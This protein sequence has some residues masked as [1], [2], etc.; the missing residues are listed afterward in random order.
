[1]AKKA[2]DFAFSGKDKFTIKQVDEQAK[3]G[4]VAG[5]GPDGSGLGSQKSGGIPA[6][7]LTAGNSAVGAMIAG[8]KTK[9]TATDEPVF[10]DIGSST[11]KLKVVKKKTYSKLTGNYFID[12]FNRLNDYLIDHSKIK[13]RD[14]ATFFRLLAIMLNSGVPLIKSLDTL[15]IQSEKSPKLKN[16]IFDLARS[17]EKGKSLSQA[18]TPYPEVFTE[19]QIGM[20]RSGEVTGQLNIILSDLAKDAESSAQIQNKVK[21]AMTYPVVILVIMTIV[22]VIMMVMVLPQMA[23]LFTQSGQELPLITRTLIAISDFMVANGWVILAGIGG[24]VAVIAVILK[25]PRGHYIWDKLKLSLPVFGPIFKKSAL[26]RFASSLGNL[27]ASGI[28]IVQSLQIVSKA[29]GNDVYKRLL[30][31]AA[32]DLKKGIPLAENLRESKYFPK[33]LVNM[34]EVGEQTA[35]LEEVTRKISDFYTDEVN[36]TVASLSK[37]MEPLLI[38]IIGVLVGGLVAAI[39]L[40]IMQ[41]TEVAGSI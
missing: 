17:V 10:F 8:D 31:F 33:M 15:A 11:S 38:A 28:S 9:V 35:Q 29:I 34:I 14:L 7:N 18:M 13:S 5:V 36:T 6:I 23:Q 30:L 2:S 4:S 25:T 20:V 19:A 1:M 22:I 27:L 26:A 32:E 16:V 40:P 39:M 37:I 41:L 12:T 21:G 24:L 3:N